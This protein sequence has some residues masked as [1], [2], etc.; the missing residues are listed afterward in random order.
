MINLRKRATC[1]RDKQY[2]SSRVQSNDHQDA[3]QTQGR[4]DESSENINKDRRYK[5]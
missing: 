4:I 1:S 5:E 2:I 3:Q